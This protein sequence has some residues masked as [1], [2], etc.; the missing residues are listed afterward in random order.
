MEARENI[1]GQATET[2]A[3]ALIPQKNDKQKWWQQITEYSLIVIFIVMFLTMSLTVDHFFSIENMLGLAL[4]ISQI[5]MVACTM[6]FCLASRD[7]DLSVGSTIAFAGVLCA[8]VLNATDNTAIA[9]VAAVAA[10]AVIGF[11]NG[12]VIAYL[13]INALITTLATMEIVRGLGFIVSH[14]QAVGVSS[15]T[16]IALGSLSMLGIS[17]PI[18]VTLACFIVFG[19]LLNQTV[20][21]RNTLA[22]GGNPEASRLAGINVERTRVWIFL[23]QGAV[24][25]LAGV[26]LASRITSGQPNAAQGFELNVISACVLGGV[27]LLGGRATISGVVIGVLIMGTV[28]NVMNLL[29]IDAFYQYLVRGAILLAAVLLDQLKNRGSRD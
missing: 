6:M 8:M 28:E 29:N 21:G 4:S 24:T 12:A 2:V 14:G 17:L 26:I 18:W 13:R 9:I 7:F 11:V 23:I 15:D 19:V 5:G 20:Y 3:N 16:F 25:A 1:V 22:I 27:S 10:G